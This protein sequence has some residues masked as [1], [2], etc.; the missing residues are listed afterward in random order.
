MSAPASGWKDDG[1]RRLATTSAGAGTGTRQRRCKRCRWYDASIIVAGTVI[2]GWLVETAE[3][4]TEALAGYY[5]DLRTVR[6]DGLLPETKA[7]VRG[8]QL[9][10][11]RLEEAR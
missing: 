7:F 11:K 1:T 3:S 9:Q 6:E 4:E 5:Q 2:L 8:V 10:R